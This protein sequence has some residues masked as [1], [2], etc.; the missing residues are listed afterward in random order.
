[1]ANAVSQN[2]GRQWPQWVESRHGKFG[3]KAD[4]PSWPSTIPKR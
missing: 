2:A 1:M 3:W 4:I